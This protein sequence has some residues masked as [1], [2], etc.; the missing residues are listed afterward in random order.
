M[1]DR[2]SNNLA[3]HAA[4]RAMVLQDDALSMVDRNVLAQ[5]IYWGNGAH[6]DAHSVADYMAALRIKQP[7][8]FCN[9]TAKLDQLGYIRITRRR[10]GTNQYEV[11]DPDGCLYGTPQWTP[12][13][14]QDVVS[15]PANDPPAPE[16]H[17]ATNQGQEHCISTQSLTDQGLH[18]ATNRTLHFVKNQYKEDSTKKDT[19]SRE[20]TSSSPPASRGSGLFVEGDPSPENPA[21]PKRQRKPVPRPSDPWRDQNAA[22][23]RAAARGFTPDRCHK[24]LSELLVRSGDDRRA[25]E[26]A[27]ARL[28]DTTGVRKPWPFLMT[29]LELYQD[30]AERSARQAEEVQVW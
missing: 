8:T 21:Q 26:F 9:S 22:R 2:A 6:Q 18:L 17:V 30:R 10:R 15:E 5:M 23:L 24:A 4:H 14:D 19:K 25:I 13:R 1:S 3:A 20:K 27:I 29:G 28:E 12:N 11:L 16:L 7:R